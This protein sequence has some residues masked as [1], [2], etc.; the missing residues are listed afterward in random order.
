[1]FTRTQKKEK[2]RKRSWEKETPSLFRFP[3]FLMLVVSNPHPT[4]L[5]IPPLSPSSC[6]VHFPI[7]FLFFFRFFS[8]SFLRQ[9]L[10]DYKQGGIK[11][12]K[13]VQQD[14]NYPKSK[15]KNKNEEPFKVAENK[16]SLLWNW[17]VCFFSKKS[18]VSLAVLENICYYFP[19]STISN[20]F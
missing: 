16:Q 19:P 7:F 11:V 20:S 6:L 15:R 13:I 5:A 14:R 2:K 10:K 8:S 18:S 12:N 3:F 17:R 9:A 1:M 4:I